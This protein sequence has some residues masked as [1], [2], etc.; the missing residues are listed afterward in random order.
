MR[1]NHYVKNIRNCPRTEGHEFTLKLLIDYSP[2]WLY[3]DKSWWNSE[4]QGIES[5]K[6]FKEKKQVTYKILGIKIESDSSM[7]TQMAK[8]KWNNT[9]KF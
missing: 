6:S 2:K 4:N 9:F 7:I 8:E 1:R 5:L 3:Q